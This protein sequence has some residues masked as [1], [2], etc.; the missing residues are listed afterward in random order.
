M[1]YVYGLSNCEETKNIRGLLKKHRISHFY[2]PRGSDSIAYRNTD[3]EIMDKYK[4]K[5]FPFVV[6]SIIFNLNLEE[7]TCDSKEQ[8]VGGYEKF[9]KYLLNK[10]ESDGK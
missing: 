3:Q 4:A 5:K 1:F 6:D 10:A 2:F 8:F 9:K 7:E